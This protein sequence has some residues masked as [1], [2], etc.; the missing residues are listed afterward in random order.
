[1]N[2]E[3]ERLATAYFDG[4]L[5]PDVQ[6]RLA[7][8]CTPDVQ[9][10]EVLGEFTGMRGFDAEVLSRQRQIAPGLRI[11]ILQMVADDSECAVRWRVSGEL[12]DAAAPISTE[13]STWFRISNGLID[14]VWSCWDAVNLLQLFNVPVQRS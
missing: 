8:L 11:D 6:A 7:R 9:F 10:H 4:L 12:P 1:V 3:V 14:E 5:R 13:G 2:A